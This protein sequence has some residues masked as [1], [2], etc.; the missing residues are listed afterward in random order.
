MA[1]DIAG[2]K[3]FEQIQGLLLPAPPGAL[4]VDVQDFQLL[5]FWFGSFGW[6]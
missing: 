3:T 5:P 4:G 2:L 6:F 1:D